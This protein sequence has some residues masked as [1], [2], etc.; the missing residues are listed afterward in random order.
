MELSRDVFGNRSLPG[1]LI[2][3]GHAA[4]TP[5]EGRDD[6]SWP[7]GWFI[8]PSILL[9]TL[10]WAGIIYAVVSWAQG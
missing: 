8:L 10:A 3:N 5:Y 6:N 1:S 4:V 9:G 2:G 7:K